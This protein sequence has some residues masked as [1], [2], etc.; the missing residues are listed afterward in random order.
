MPALALHGAA[1]AHGDAQGAQH[2]LWHWSFEPWVV[3]PL[4]LAL[5]LYAMGAARLWR[6]AG[7]GRGLRP[8][9]ALAF[10]GGWLALVGALV[11]PL[12]ALGDRLFSAH[13][14]QHEMLM[15][16]AAPLLVLG[17]PLAAFAW[18]LPRSAL[19]VFA[20][21]FRSH[22]PGAL[23]SALTDPLAAWVLHALALWVWHVPAL[24]DAA[25]ENESL[26]TLQHTSFL[27]SALLFWWAALGRDGRS[28]GQGAAMLLLFTTMLHTSALGALLAL[29]PTPWY[30]HYLA[31][32]AG[33]GLDPLEDQQ[34]GGLVMWVPGGLAY[35]AAGL[36]VGARWL[37][38]RPKPGP[39]AAR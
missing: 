12:D 22:W 6:Q 21:P 19:R 31:S 29:A 27:A 7:A 16:V 11:S 8:L 15:L 33:L 34:L 28:R 24:F 14:V 2:P 5:L 9:Q 4:L 30:P 10:A 36:A 13:M 32:G 18:A 39:L 38:R 20:R 37:A 1:L 23:W 25:V 3:G 26:H 35:L 17:R